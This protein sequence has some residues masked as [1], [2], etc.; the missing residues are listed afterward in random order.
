MAWCRQAISQ[1]M[2]LT[3]VSVRRRMVSLVGPFSVADLE[4]AQ[5]MLIQ[6]CQ[7]Q[8]RLLK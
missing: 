5:T 7:S 6:S 2:L 3:Q 4:L 1:P 8:A